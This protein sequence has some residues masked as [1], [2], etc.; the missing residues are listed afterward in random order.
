MNPYLPVV[1][2][3]KCAKMVMSTPRKVEIE[4][5][6]RCNLRCKY[7]CHFA[8]EGDVSRELGYAEWNSFFSECGKNG[9]MNIHL[10]GG[11][12][13]IRK[14]ILNILQSVVDN[15]MR[16]GCN[17][18]GNYITE[19][20]AE[21]I[22]RSNRCNV[23]QVS[24]DGHTAEV[25]DSFRGIGSFQKA[26]QAI[27]LLNGKGIR[28][29]IRVTIHKKNVHHLKEIAEFIFHDLNIPS[30]STNSAMH[31]GLMKENHDEIELNVEEYSL[32][33]QSVLEINEQYPNGVTGTAGPIADAHFWQRMIDAVD[34]NAEP[35]NGCGTLNSCGCVG[36]TLAVRADG[37]YVPC[38]Q[39]DGEVLGKINVDSMKE[40][41]QKSKGLNTFRDRRDIKLSEF[42]KCKSCEFQNYCRGGC[43][44]IISA[45]RNDLYIPSTIDCLKTFLENGGVMPSIE[46]IGAK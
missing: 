24:L 6:P 20:V 16:F 8:S 45:L 28:V 22:A 27:H 33:M 41:W 30:F 34:E 21:Y 14:D 31:M 1:L 39:I 38:N 35:F 10:S 9:V 46:L 11:E 13:F 2:L 12:P 4:I 44:A 19:E 29:G 17:T 7:C 40:V 5:T 25:H 23:I 32:A 43:P 37:M 36:N 18:N 42:E 15:N 3:A 26:V